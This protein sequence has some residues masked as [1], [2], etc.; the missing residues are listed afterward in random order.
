MFIFQAHGVVHAN[1]KDVLQLMT[2]FWQKNFSRSDVSLEQFIGWLIGKSPFSAFQLDKKEM[3]MLGFISDVILKSKLYKDQVKG[4]SKF[5]EENTN[6]LDEFMAGCTTVLAYAILA[7]LKEDDKL[8]KE[9]K[10]NEIGRDAFEIHINNSIA[11]ICRD[12]TCGM[13]DLKE[14]VEKTYS[15]MLNK[16]PSWRDAP[17]GGAQSRAADDDRPR[18]TTGQHYTKDYYEHLFGTGS[19][20][21]LEDVAKD[22]AKYSIDV[23]LPSLALK[24]VAASA[25]GEGPH[26]PPF[27]VRSEKE[28]QAVERNRRERSELQDLMD[29]EEQKNA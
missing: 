14:M 23:V 29:K 2:N 17:A 28:R 25:K 16:I 12:G 22:L 1:E 6:A 13:Y 9:Y 15:E 7:K 24:V 8:Y 19:Y 3:E 21:N 18:W 26:P 5:Y 4:F 20:N 11:G 27:I 10:N